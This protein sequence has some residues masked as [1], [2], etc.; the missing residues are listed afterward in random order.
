MAA[1][2][3]EKIRNGGL[4]MDLDDVRT[5]PKPCHIFINNTHQKLI[6]LVESVRNSEKQTLASLFLEYW[7][8]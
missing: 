6:D 4:G 1:S 8:C 3:E 2:Q 5:I 7:A